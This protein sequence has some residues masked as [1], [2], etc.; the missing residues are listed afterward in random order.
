MLPLEDG[1]LDSPREAEA[2][3]IASPWLQMVSMPSLMPKVSNTDSRARACSSF[4]FGLKLAED[5]AGLGDSCLSNAGMSNETVDAIVCS[6]W[7]LLR[8]VEML[9]PASGD[10]YP[11]EARA[12]FLSDAWP[13]YLRDRL[14]WLYA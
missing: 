10:V 8:P 1:Y 7:S 2:G 6:G 3:L 14:K 5:N 12:C 11:G 13:M 9:V 4:F